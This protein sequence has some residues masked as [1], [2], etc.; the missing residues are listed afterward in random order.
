MLKQFG[1]VCASGL[2]HR[3]NQSSDMRHER[4]QHERDGRLPVL[5]ASTSIAHHS[6]IMSANHNC[7]VVGTCFSE[8]CQRLL[9][10]VLMLML[11]LLPG[12]QLSPAHFTGGFFLFPPTS[13]PEGQVQVKYIRRHSDTTCT[14]TLG[15]RLCASLS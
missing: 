2:G 10:S 7:F 15:K 11:L 9:L 14:L 3:K 8:Q 1:S 5:P 6:A 13:S 4:Q 12:A